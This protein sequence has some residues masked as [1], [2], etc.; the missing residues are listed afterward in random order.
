MIYVI[1]LISYAVSALVFN[2]STFQK[3]KLTNIMMTKTH[4]PIIYDLGVTEMHPKTVS[5]ALRHC[6][7]Y[8]TYA[9]RNVVA[10]HTTQAFDSAVAFVNEFYGDKKRTRQPVILDSGCGQGLS[11]LNLAKANPNIPVLGIDRSIN[12]LSRNVLENGGEWDESGDDHIDNEDELPKGLSA[13]SF[14]FTKSYESYPNLFL[15]RA[16]ISDFWMLAA[17]VSNW[18]VKEHYILYPNP[19]PKFKH[20]QRRWHGHS[21]FPLLLSLGGDLR[22][23]SNWKVYCDEM[24]SSIQQVTPK[25]F[26]PYTASLASLSNGVYT[27]NQADAPMTHFERKYLAVNLTLYQTQFSMPS[28]AKTKRNS[29]LKMMKVHEDALS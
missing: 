24:H 25:Y 19:Y 7:T 2:P 5:T 8:G 18:V 6:A 10:L 13:Q 3:C 26:E 22:V 28:L 4:D 14:P 23:R 27:P 17:T 1:I 12:R 29:L 21:C 11:T 15:I 16:E 20:L 9:R